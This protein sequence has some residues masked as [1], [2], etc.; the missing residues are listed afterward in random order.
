MHIGDFPPQTAFNKLHIHMQ[1]YDQNESLRTQLKESKRTENLL[2]EQVDKAQ[3]K[4]SDLHELKTL[5]SSEDLETQLS[6]MQRKMSDVKSEFGSIDTI[7]MHFTELTE[8][9]NCYACI[10]CT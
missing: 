1:V 9:V 8:Q 7:K 5:S 10:H 4:L 6:I 3:K 2:Q